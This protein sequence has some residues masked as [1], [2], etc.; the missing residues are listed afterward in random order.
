MEQVIN[1][2]DMLADR[3]GWKITG[4]KKNELSKRNSSC[5]A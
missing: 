2:E 4:G 5:C 1:R 3:G